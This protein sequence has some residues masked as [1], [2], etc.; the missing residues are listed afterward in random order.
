MPVRTVEFVIH[1]KSNRVLKLHDSHLCWGDWRPTG[2]PTAVIAPGAEGRI[3][4]ESGGPTSGTTGWVKYHFSP[5]KRVSANDVELPPY[6]I[7]IAWDNPFFSGLTG[8]NTSFGR[9]LSA[10]ADIDVNCDRLTPHEVAQS[11]SVLG[12]SR[13]LKYFQFVEGARSQ[14]AS[15]DGAYWSELLLSAGLTFYGTGYLGEAVAA[16]G[17]LGIVAHPVVDLSFGEYDHFPEQA[18]TTL[19]AFVPM[20][21]TT[22]GPIADVD[23]AF[24]TQRWHAESQ[25]GRSIRLDFSPQGDGQLQCVVDEHVITPFSKTFK[26]LHPQFAGAEPFAGDQWEPVD[27]RHGARFRQS[28][29]NAEEVVWQRH[30]NAAAAARGKAALAHGAAVR[31]EN[32]P[33]V[34]QFRATDR[35]QLGEVGFVEAY[36]VFERGIPVSKRL[37]YVRYNAR[38]NPVCD[39]MLNAAHIS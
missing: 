15:G 29:G 7:S 1:N 11:A 36:S 39:L 4:A 38:Y 18:S 24:W 3:R 30:G 19:P 9:G 8:R 10:A 33:M 34:K 32:G 16:I 6:T 28:T 23:A 26:D 20:T 35:I 2:P 13:E 21:Q 37:R 25:D 17:F 31:L 22:L 5:G 12:G 27:G 14:D